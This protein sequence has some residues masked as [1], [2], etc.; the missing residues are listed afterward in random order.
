MKRGEEERLCGESKGE[1]MPEAVAARRIPFLPPE[2]GGEGGFVL[3]SLP[4]TTQRRLGACE[5]PTLAWQTLSN[6]LPGSAAQR[7]AERE[8]KRHELTGARALAV[9]PRQPQPQPQSQQQQKQQQQ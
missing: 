2:C 7:T 8:G 9:N 6:E 1:A 5:G 3:L 4:A